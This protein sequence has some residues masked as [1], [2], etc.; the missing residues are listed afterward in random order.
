MSARKAI[1]EKTQVRV[2]P[3][4][5]PARLRTAAASDAAAK[6]PGA[7]HS[8]P[9]ASKRSLFSSRTAGRTP[10]RSSPATAAALAG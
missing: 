10:W 9:L 3:Q 5:L 1:E 2:V 7:H 6:A 4:E 8:W